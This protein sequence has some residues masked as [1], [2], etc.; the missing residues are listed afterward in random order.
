MRPVP[1]SVLVLSALLAGCAGLGAPHTPEALEAQDQRQ[2]R[3]IHTDLIRGMLDQAQYYAALA[4]IDEQRNRFGE[5]P[6]LEILRAEALARIGDRNGA[7]AAYQKLLRGPYAAQAHHG[8]GLLYADLVPSAALG[9]LSR[10]ARL[11]PT[12][13]RIRND[14]GYALLRAGR[15]DEAERELATAVQLAP[16][17]PRYAANLVLALLVKGQAQRALDVARDAG[18]SEEALA[19]LRLQAQRVRTG[20]ANGGAP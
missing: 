5:R 12:D 7:E 4:H 18:L 17:T 10:A 1:A 6:E 2:E 16:G 9:H 11:A 3:G 14:Y 15:L 13:A 20:L 19:A 8:L